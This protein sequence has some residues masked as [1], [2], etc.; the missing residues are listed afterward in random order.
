M[1]CRVFNFTRVVFLINKKKIINNSPFT[2]AAP[3][4]LSGCSGKRD[5]D[6]DDGGEGCEW[7]DDGDDALVHDELPEGAVQV[8]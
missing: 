4:F 6:E 8:V 3:R 2:V 1:S 7:R 5:G